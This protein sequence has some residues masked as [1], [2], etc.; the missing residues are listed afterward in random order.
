[1]MRFVG[2]AALVAS[3]GLVGTAQA[4]IVT[5]TY[6]GEVL[7]GVDGGGLFGTAGANLT[8]LAYSTTY[9]FDDTYA[10][11]DSGSVKAVGG[12]ENGQP[13]PLIYGETTINGISQKL[14]N[15]DY[16]AGYGVNY[17]LGKYNN[18]YYFGTFSSLAAVAGVGDNIHNACFTAPSPMPHFGVCEN[19][20]DGYFRTGGTELFLSTDFVA[21]SQPFKLGTSYVPEP[22]TWA[23]MIMGFG[24]VGGALRRRA[25]YA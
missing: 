1:M 24:L 9:A 12:I 11:T 2:M 4:A 17:T 13:N 25:L 14:T 8:G 3:V 22:A 20:A 6:T 15:G 18:L 16:L 5:F 10:K 7:S 23:M 21:S 19:H